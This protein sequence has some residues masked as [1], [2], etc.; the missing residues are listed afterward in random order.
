MTRYQWRYYTHGL[1]A[2][3][4]SSDHKGLAMEHVLSYTSLRSRLKTTIPINH[5]FSFW[6]GQPSFY[7]TM[8]S[9]PQKKYKAKSRNK[10]PNATEHHSRYLPSNERTPMS[11]FN[12]L[13]CPDWIKRLGPSADDGLPEVVK[14]ERRK[15]KWQQHPA[16]YDVPES[17]QPGWNDNWRWLLRKPHKDKN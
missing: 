17:R 4:V 3:L 5:S 14:A 12:L 1:T 10:K 6:W 16:L 8:F 9:L 15:N 7:N 11:F 2:L 13:T